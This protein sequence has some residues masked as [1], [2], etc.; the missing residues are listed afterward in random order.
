MKALTT[1]SCPRCL[2][3]HDIGGTETP[4]D[5]VCPCGVTLVCCTVQVPTGPTHRESDYAPRFVRY[6]CA[7]WKP[8][9]DVDARKPPPNP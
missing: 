7:K 2:A 6:W 9:D 3:S 8:G 1:S 5:I 4:A